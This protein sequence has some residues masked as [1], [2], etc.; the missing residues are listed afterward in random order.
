MTDS[1]HIALTVPASVDMALITGPGDD[2]LRIIQSS[3]DVRIGVRGDLISLAGDPSD[4]QSLTMLFSDLIKVVEEGGRPD[5]DYVRRA[6][7]L[8]RADEFSPRA[9]REDILLTYRGRAIRPKTAGQKRYVDAIRSHTITFGIGPAGTGKT[10]LAMAMAVAALKRKECGRIV[11]TRPVVEAGENL[12]FLPGTL[13][14]KVDPYIRPLY[15]ALF[16]MTDMERARDLIE[17]GVIEIAPLAFMRGRTLNDS[18]II[19]DEAQNAT[20]EQMKMFLTRLGFGSKMI[21]TG[22]A[23]QLDLPR[24]KSGLMDVERILGGIDDIAFCTFSGADVVRHTLVGAIVSA[25][26]QAARKG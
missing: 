21:I 13:E 17:G 19:L 6:I 1:T 2:L 3:F 9:L 20:A 22:D 11:L 5:A 24:G 12:G 15:D 7:E 23:T 8:L 4:V 18:F 16:D 25:Y 10:Y 26:E 14:E